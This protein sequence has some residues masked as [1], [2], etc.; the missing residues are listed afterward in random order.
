MASTIHHHRRHLAVVMPNVYK[1]LLYPHMLIAF[2]LAKTQK[3]KPQQSENISEN[4][5]R[6]RLGSV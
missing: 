6:R 5:T 3:R 1:D 2:W 4:A